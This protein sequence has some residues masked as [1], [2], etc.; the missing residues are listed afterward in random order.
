MLYLFYFLVLTVAFIE[1]CKAMYCKKVY[2]QTKELRSIKNDKTKR[3]AYLKEHISLF[4]LAMAELFVCWPV[5]LAGLL[6]SQWPIFLFVIL[7]SFTR[8]QR[9]G[10]WAVFIDS[11]LTMLVLVFAVINAVHLHIPLY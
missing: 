9:L 7:F 11:V 5:M 6:T 3:D 1:L 2:A 10:A 8:F 4:C